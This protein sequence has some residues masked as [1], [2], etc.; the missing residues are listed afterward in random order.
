[1][2]CV[3]TKALK[4]LVGALPVISIDPAI[5]EDGRQFYRGFY[6]NISL[7]PD[8]VTD[9]YGLM[10]FNEIDPR[11]IIPQTHESEIK[12]KTSKQIISLWESSLTRV[13]IPTEFIGCASDEVG[14]AYALCRDTKKRITLMNRWLFA[15]YLRALRPDALMVDALNAFNGLAFYRAGKCVGMAMGMRT[16]L[17]FFEEYDLHGKAFDL[18]D[19]NEAIG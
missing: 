9:G 14:L 18:P 15:F 13:Y 12:P 5:G 8:W 1:M 4:K 19:F 2:R 10:P 6:G 11:M 7:D 3:S 16:E 17:S